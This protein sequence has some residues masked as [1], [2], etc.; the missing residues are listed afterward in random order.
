MVRLIS[1]QYLQWYLFKYSE[2]RSVLVLLTNNESASWDYVRKLTE[3]KN[4]LEDR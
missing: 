1:K 3:L 2:N 4:S